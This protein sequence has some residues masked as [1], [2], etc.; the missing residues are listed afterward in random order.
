MK[1]YEIT[2][3]EYKGGQRKTPTMVDAPILLLAIAER[4]ERLVE[5]LDKPKEGEGWTK[6]CILFQAN[7]YQAETDRSNMSRTL[8]NILSMATGSVGYT[9]CAF[10]IYR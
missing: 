7:S 9:G 1:N 4:L 3:E 5:V 6:D 2:L 8:P 10:P